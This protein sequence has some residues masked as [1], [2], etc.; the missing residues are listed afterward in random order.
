MDSYTANTF[1][2]FLEQ[3]F[4]N[5]D[6]FIYNNMAFLDIEFNLYSSPET[7]WEPGYCE[8]EVISITVENDGQYTA[9]QL[10]LI[11]KV[12]LDNEQ[13]IE[14]LFADDMVDSYEPYCQ[15]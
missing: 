2:T 11:E 7:R 13:K 8:I 6:D 5:V 9:E 1:D 3:S 14:D 4:L 15:Y 12:I 10:Q